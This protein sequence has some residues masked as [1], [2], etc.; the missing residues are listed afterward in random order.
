MWTRPLF[1]NQTLVSENQGLSH[2]SSAR[3]NCHTFCVVTM[4]T[5]VWD[6][7]CVSDLITTQLTCTSQGSIS[8]PAKAQICSLNTGRACHK[9]WNSHEST[10][11]DTVIN[12]PSFQY[13]HATVA[14][15]PTKL[16]YRREDTVALKSRWTAYR[17]SFSE[18]S[19]M[20]P[21]D[22]LHGDFPV[23]WFYHQFRRRELA[24]YKGPAF[25]VW[26]TARVCGGCYLPPGFLWSI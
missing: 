9:C 23:H 16:C 13:T 8:R 24:Q 11:H 14:R 26:M 15:S 2:T 3:M 1:A 21:R 7:L 25:V 10:S 18:N 5:Q 17:G 12:K 22:K 4:P 19:G 20:H 6:T